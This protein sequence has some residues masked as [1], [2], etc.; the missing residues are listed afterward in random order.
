MY[1]VHIYN[2]GDRDVEGAAFEDKEE[3]MK[4]INENIEFWKARHRRVIHPT[5]NTWILSMKPNHVT[6]FSLIEK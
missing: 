2:V 5:S 3:A 1:L 6:V 4:L